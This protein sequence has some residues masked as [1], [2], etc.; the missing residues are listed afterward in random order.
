MDFTSI[1]DT[2]NLAA[3][4][5]G[6]NKAYASKSIITES[7]FV[8]V[9]DKF[10]CR[11]LDFIAVKGKTEPVR[12]FEILQEKG[13]ASP[14]HTTIAKA[15]ETGLTAYRARQWNDAA[16]AFHGLVTDYQDGPSAIFL[17]RVA[18]FQKNPPSDDWDGVFR[19]E[20]K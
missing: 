11:E 5:E 17:E 13:S 16:S 4:L 19:M 15:F 9:K 2:V 6:A 10:V 8:E 18:H 7:V 3:R 12:I 14:R 1:G 20:V